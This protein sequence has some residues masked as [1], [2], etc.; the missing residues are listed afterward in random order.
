MI[1]FASDVNGKRV[2]HEFFGLSKDEKPIDKINGV[3]ITNGSMFIEMDTKKVY[4]FD[5]ENQ[6]WLEQ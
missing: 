1:T 3:K 4:L 6:I 2:P 5:E